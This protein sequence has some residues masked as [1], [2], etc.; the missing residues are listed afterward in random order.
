MSGVL[1]VV[2]G[3]LLLVLVL[4]PGRSRWRSRRRLWSL[5]VDLV[6]SLWAMGFILNA[7][8]LSPSSGLYPTLALAGPILV[9]IAYN[10]SS[11]R[12]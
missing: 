11:R 9:L 3:G 8:P 7:T 5:G 6:I 2:G 10:I 4:F 1:S 12:Q